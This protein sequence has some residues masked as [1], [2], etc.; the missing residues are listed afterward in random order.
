MK[1]RFDRPENPHLSTHHSPA[2]VLG[3]V[4]DGFDEQRLE[5][6]SVHRATDGMD[7]RRGHWWA[8]SVSVSTCSSGAARA[9]RL[10]ILATFAASCVW[11]ICS[12]TCG[13]RGLFDFSDV[14]E[15]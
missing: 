14:L 2:H 1:R 8:K 5:D 4:V 9:I 11:M 3:D 10:A 12:E 13:F 6:P 7:R 15:E